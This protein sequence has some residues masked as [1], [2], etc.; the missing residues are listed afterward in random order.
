MGV[1]Y[2]PPNSNTADFNNCVHFEI[3]KTACKPCYMMGDFNLDILKYELLPQIEKF[4]DTT[5]AQ[6]Y[7]CY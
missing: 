2:R 4:L 6:F 7:T 3:E 5:Y 1:V